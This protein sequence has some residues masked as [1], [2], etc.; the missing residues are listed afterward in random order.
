[1]RIAHWILKATNTHSEYV[2][3]TAIPL[4]LRLHKYTHCY[5]IHTLFVLLSTFRAEQILAPVDV[6][7]SYTVFGR[8]ANNCYSN[9]TI[10]INS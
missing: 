7:Y 8:V 1:M 5:I 3:L 10:I 6:N 4:Q 9:I 2:I